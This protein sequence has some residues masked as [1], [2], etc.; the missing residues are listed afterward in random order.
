[1]FLSFHRILYYNFNYV[2]PA[3]GTCRSITYNAWQLLQNSQF[4]F[5]APFTISSNAFRTQEWLDLARDD[6][7]RLRL[8]PPLVSLLVGW[9]V[10]SNEAYCSYGVLLLICSIMFTANTMLLKY[11]SSLYYTDH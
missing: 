7:S 9:L 5:K 2:A 8:T 3:D 11:L 1:M 10:G 4:Q 6:F